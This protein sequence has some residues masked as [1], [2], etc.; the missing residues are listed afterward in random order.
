MC[1][2]S[3]NGGSDIKKK[4]KKRANITVN[5]QNHGYIF[6]FPEKYIPYDDTGQRAY[7]NACKKYKALLSTSFY[8]KLGESTNIDMRHY[9]AGPRGGQAIAI[10]LVVSYSY[11]H[12]TVSEVINSHVGESYFLILFG[13]PCNHF[14]NLM[15]YWERF[16][17]PEYWSDCGRGVHSIK[18]FW[19]CQPDY[20]WPVLYRHYCP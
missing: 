20:N 9:N 10:P 4:K 5:T 18:L 12:H 16:L 13:T 2:T 19:S 14:N 1:F 15:L 7:E 6:F 3:G 8:Q 11:S 17:Q